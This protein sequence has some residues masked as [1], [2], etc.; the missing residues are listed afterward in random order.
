MN[1]EN[2]WSPE[3]WKQIVDKVNQDGQFS[4]AFQALAKGIAPVSDFPLT[5]EACQRLLPAFVADEQLGINVGEKYAE[6]QTHL[7]T[8]ELCEA[9]YASLLDIQMDE[10]LEEAS[11]SAPSPLAPYTQWH[12]IAQ[13]EQ[14]D[15]LLQ[16]ARYFVREAWP[17]EQ[18]IFR[19][20]STAY[21]QNPRIALQPP[22]TLAPL[23]GFGMGGKVR[24][25]TPYVLSL[26]DRVVLPTLAE[27]VSNADTA[28]TDIAN[29]VK[30][31]LEFLASKDPI[32]LG[33]FQR[34]ILRRDLLQQGSAL[35]Y[36]SPADL[37]T[38]ADLVSESVI[39]EVSG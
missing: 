36:L 34:A 21:F 19:A 35:S 3:E 24:V 12:R 25:V 39:V 9:A 10:W 23:L 38:L 33:V 13:P 14:R 6:V 5:H 20:V 29:R 2:E 31:T 4:P 28:V 18:I 30:S 32:Y 37:A 26:V 16:V 27:A 8:C 7:E 17:E 22:A 11:I 1:S 15:L